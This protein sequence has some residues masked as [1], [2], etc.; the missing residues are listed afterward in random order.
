MTDA[1]S[2]YH[3]LIELYKRIYDDDGFFVK[4]WD[5]LAGAGDLRDLEYRH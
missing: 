3:E 4:E 1:D 5:R 2:E